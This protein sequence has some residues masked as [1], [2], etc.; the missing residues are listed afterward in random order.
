V[1]NYAGGIVLVDGGFAITYFAMGAVVWLAAARR[2][3]VLAVNMQVDDFTSQP[4]LADS[5][6]MRA[7][8]G[9]ETI[10]DKL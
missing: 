8:G 10:Y 4:E 6:N 5:D 2:G 3:W 9:V 7:S 1:L